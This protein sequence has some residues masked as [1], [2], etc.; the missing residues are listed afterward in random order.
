MFHIF[1]WYCLSEVVC[2]RC[3]ECRKEIMRNIL[4]DNPFPL[5]NFWKQN[6]KMRNCSKWVVSPF[7]SMFSPLFNNYSFLCVCLDIFK[8]FCN[9]F[10]VCDCHYTNDNWSL[11]CRWP[12]KTVLDY[13]GIYNSSAAVSIWKQCEQLLSFPQCFQPC[14]KKFNFQ[15]VT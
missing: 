9:R 11:R 3:V 12:L 10:V 6:W 7:A 15:D 5:Q 2:C 13:M 8:V 14:F 1:S 4:S